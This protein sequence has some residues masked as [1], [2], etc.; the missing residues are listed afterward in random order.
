MRKFLNKY[1][2]WTF[3]IVP[4]ILQ[5]VF[6]YFPMVQGAFYSLTNWTGLTYNY[7]FVGLNNYK[8]LLIDGKFFQAIIFTIILTLALII[9]EIF[10][11]MVVARALNS[12]IKGQTF[13]RAWFFFPAVLSG[14]TVSLI[15]KQFFNYGLP[16]IGKVLG[17]GFLQESLLGTSF[18]AVIATIFVLLW[19]GRSSSSLQV[20]KVFQMTFLKLQ[21]LTGL[22]LNKHSGRL[23]YHTYFLQFQW[24]SS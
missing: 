14:L 15:F 1:W 5:A 19:Q 9:G 16:T 11:G 3:L 22:P 18:G 8:L 17:I 10:I 2:G 13:F 20:F 12:K 23:S 7:K 4:I 6:F 24:S 21:L